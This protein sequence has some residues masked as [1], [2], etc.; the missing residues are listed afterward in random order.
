MHANKA[1]VLKDGGVLAAGPPGETLSGAL[2]SDLYQAEVTVHKVPYRG[3]EA[4]VSLPGG[5]K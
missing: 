1:L 5:K 4:L 3:G 2:L